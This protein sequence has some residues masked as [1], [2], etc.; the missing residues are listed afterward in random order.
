V[1]TAES[2]ATTRFDTAFAGASARPGVIA[3]VTAGFPTLDAMPEL[4]LAAESAGC[5]AVEVGIPF[6]DPLADGPV[7]Q[8]TGWRALENGMTVATALRQVAEA[9]RQGLRCPVAVMTYINPVLAYGVDRFAA[10]C[11]ASGVDGGI[12]PDLPADEAA[13][14]AAALHAHSLAHIPLVAPTTPAARIGRAAATASGFIYCVS[15]TGTT[16]AREQVAGAALDLLDRV[17]SVSTLP[18]ALGFGISRPEHVAALEGRCEAVVV[19]SA[20]LQAIE[21]G[22]DDPPAAAERYLRSLMA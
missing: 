1:S 14:V 6:S 16:G 22:A 13:E 3:Y 2:S 11:A 18:R 17:R 21:A 19:G 4:L 9:R 12:F 20:L 15:V 8:R 7:I 10:D 5:L